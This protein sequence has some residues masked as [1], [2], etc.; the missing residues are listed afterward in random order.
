MLHL[1]LLQPLLQVRVHLYK[2]TSNYGLS[3]NLD[4][5]KVPY[6]IFC[7]LSYLDGSTPLLTILCDKSELL[8]VS[9]YL[10]LSVRFASNA[11][12]KHSIGNK[13]HDIAKRIFVIAIMIQYTHLIVKTNIHIQIT[14]ISSQLNT[15]NFVFLYAVI[16]LSSNYFTFLVSSN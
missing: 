6:I 8:I 15:H 3:F 9:K 4:L 5:L 7:W 14:L 1:H 12:M 16:P 10:R 11:T 2:F 13:A